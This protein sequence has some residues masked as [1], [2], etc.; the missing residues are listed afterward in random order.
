MTR[1]SSS[2]EIANAEIVRRDRE[3]IGL[4]RVLDVSR[5]ASDIARFLDVEG[6]MEVQSSYLRYK[7]QRRCIALLHVRSR[8][9]EEQLVAT[10]MTPT[11]WRHLRSK[12]TLDL[13][14]GRLL[15]LDADQI[16]IERFPCDRKLRHVAK[17]FQPGDVRRVLKRVLK[18]MG[19]FNPD[20]PITL[21]TLAYKPARRYVSRVSVDG[22][23]VASIKLHSQASYPA[24]KLRAELLPTLPASLHT[25]SRCCDRYQAVAASWVSGINLAEQLILGVKSSLPLLRESG[26]QLAG[27]HACDPARLSALPYSEPSAETR[28]LVAL[29]DDL[30][31][32]CPQHASE[33]QRIVTRVGPD[34]RCPPSVAVIHGDF[35]A[36]QVICSGE[37]LS[38]IDFDQLAIG[39][40]YQDVG[41]F[42]ANLHWSWI[43]GQ[44]SE[45]HCASATEAF[46]QGYR[47]KAEWNEASFRR[48]L[49]IGLLKCLP[50]TFR[51]A[52]DAWPVRFSQLLQAAGECL[53][54]C[55]TPQRQQGMRPT[56]CAGKN[57]IAPLTP[58]YTPPTTDRL[59]EAI[60]SPAS[61]LMPP[62][63]RRMLHD[64]RCLRLK[65][66]RRCLIECQFIDHSPE[67]TTQRGDC[68][69]SMVA[70]AKIRFKG[71]DRRTP[72]LHRRLHR[73]GF[74]ERSEARVP[75]YL[76]MVPSLNLWFQ[77]KIVARSVPADTDAG[78]QRRVADAL[79]RLHL[80]GIT[81]DRTHSV[82]DEMDV[83]LRRL[84][85]AKHRL[86]AWRKA[87]SEIE[88]GC[89]SV[90]QAIPIGEVCLIHRDFYF[91][92]VLVND[93]QVSLLDLDLAATGPPELDVG[94]YVAHLL[95]YGLRVP[96]SAAI[97]QAAS[98]AFVQGYL[99]AN[100]TCRQESIHYWKTLA[101]ARHISIAAC[102]PDRFDAVPAIIE[103]TRALCSEPLRS[104]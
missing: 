61:Q 57:H 37:A 54:G 101:I 24:A 16:C 17:L 20:G 52:L 8:D 47:Q 81:V 100:P 99:T 79:A 51:Q 64:T 45:S 48:Q 41:N 19:S 50:H 71:L 6:P 30:S 9:R 2:A 53:S 67:R 85:E 33:I 25:R 14:H 4:G 88:R 91:D 28:K 1:D 80:C 7:P 95:E 18:G 96:Q 11:S 23:V 62:L 77:E 5:L 46:L 83:L 43:C 94:N 65:P 86:P 102:F 78:L 66:N 13:Q 29:A 35:H 82:S 32:L 3:L 89:I 92:Q 34:V 12:P 74:D 73:A 15:Y 93:K 55:T 84:G 60:A 21:S 22:S 10:A 26:Y 70:M 104:C 63:A 98:D 97:C 68:G 72:D 87:I 36:K 39:D 31:F 75:E 38:L 42:V 76:G 69:E 49:V 40:P 58:T 44:I 56:L 90:A 59:R 103:T 27:L